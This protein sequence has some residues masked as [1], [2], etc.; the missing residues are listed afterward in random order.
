MVIDRICMQYPKIKR[1]SIEVAHSKLDYIV[2]SIS[3]C[4]KKKWEL[5]VISRIIHK[6][7]DESI[8]FVTQQ[9]VRLSD[10]TRALTDLY[11]PQFQLH[12]EV[13]ES[14]HQRQILQ[15]EWR[16]QDIIA[17]TQHQLKRIVITNQDRAIK[18][19]VQ[20]NNETDQFVDY[21]LEEKRRQKIDG[22][23]MPWN[24]E[25]RFSAD[26]VL[27]RGYLDVADNVVF[28]H[29]HV[30]LRCFG[31]NGNG[32]QR[33]EWPI[34]DGSGDVVWFPRL[35]PHK[36]WHN[37]LTPDGRRIFERAISQL[38]VESIEKQRSKAEC[39][40]N[41]C[42]IV[43]AKGKNVLGENLLRYVGTFVVNTVES[44]HDV[45]CFDLV[46]YREEL[47]GS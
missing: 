7:D 14:H 44:T 32:Y 30:A 27:E 5:Y 20:L 21:V 22:V 17:R 6:L 43:F 16:E 25:R 37:E 23:F 33:G 46:R 34:P 29:Q 24:W 36:M 19:V 31:F 13:D 11:F 3:K 47:R 40:P 28:Q 4:A 42:H 41:R 10:G 35:Y 8:E 2:S 38:G 12:L 45:L 9:L 1:K 39:Q 18:N 15:D 26:I